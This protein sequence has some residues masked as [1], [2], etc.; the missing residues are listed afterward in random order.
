MQIYTSTLVGPLEVLEPIDPDDS[1]P[2]EVFWGAPVFVPGE[3]YLRDSIMRPLVPNGYY[4]KCTISGITGAIEPSA[5]DIKTFISGYAK[6]KALS[7]DLFL[8]WED[9]IL[10]SS[11]EVTDGVTLT[12][13]A[14]DTVRTGVVISSIPTGVT[15]F[16]LTNQ[17]FKTGSIPLSRSLLITVHEQ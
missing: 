8:S 5:S 1:T 16:T 12:A 9:E 7:Y 3:I 6:F 2:I 17:V 15:S 13:Q 14:H 4:Y 10:S 11:W